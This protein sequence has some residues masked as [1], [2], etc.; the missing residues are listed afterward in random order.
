MLIMDE[1]RNGSRSPEVFPARLADFGLPA[2]VLVF[3]PYFVDEYSMSCEGLGQ[4]G[5]RPAWQ[6]RFQQRPDRP[7]RISSYVAGHRTF[8]K[9]LKGRA[10]IAAD[11]YQIVHLE[12]DLLEPIPEVLLV[13]EHFAIN[14]HPVRFA[15]DNV[16]LWLPES[17][18]VYM[19]V[20]G[21]LF[22]REHIFS[23]YLLFSVD[24]NQKIAEPK[25][26]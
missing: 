11:T 23:D 26:R 21:R 18:H 13:R 17:A 1:S 12:T 2:I 19:N 7:A 24:I 10:W 22:R 20:R 8:A 3:H 4:W 6:V 16:E 5:G 15:K 14:Y 9:K 25:E